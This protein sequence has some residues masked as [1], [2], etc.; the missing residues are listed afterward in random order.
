MSV[1]L[2][3]W[4]FSGRCGGHQGQ[5]F[6]FLGDHIESVEGMMCTELNLC[7]IDFANRR[8]VLL[9]RYRHVLELLQKGLVFGFTAG[10]AR[11]G[12]STNLQLELQLLFLL[13]PTDLYVS[14]G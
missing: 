11:S 7:K 5:D 3:L 14:P 2:I 10:A 1:S 4:K 12:L 9:E 13:E 8:I 6:E